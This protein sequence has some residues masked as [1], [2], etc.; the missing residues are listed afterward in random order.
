MAAEGYPGTPRTGD[1]IEGLDA[2]RP[3]GRLRHARRHF[4]SP[5]RLGHDERGT[6]ARGR[7]ARRH[8]PASFPRRLRPRRPHP[9]ARRASSDATSAVAPCPH[10]RRTD[11]T[12]QTSPRSPPF[13]TTSRS[14]LAAS[15]PW[16]RPPTTSSPP[17]S[18]PRSP[19]ATRTTWCA[20][21]FPRARA[22]RGTPRPRAC[23]R[24]GAK[25]A[26]SCATRSLP[27][28]ATTRPSSLRALP[29]ERRPSA[30]AASSRWCAW[31]PSRSASCSL[32]SA[33]CRGPRRT[34]C[35]SS[36]RRART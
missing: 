18:A 13:A 26:R 7:R 9:L 3:P 33:R 30:G 8:A 35:A 4:P 6:C 24:S 14:S 29:P 21:S 19:R 15:G 10:L 1:R 20:S 28:T 27:S 17:E 12:W 25:R 36:A 34:G 5:G 31:C 22:T 11:P 16:W 32:T 23:W 2:P